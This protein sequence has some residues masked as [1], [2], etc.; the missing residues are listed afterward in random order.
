MNVA[1]IFEAGA[2]TA[3]SPELGLISGGDGFILP[4]TSDSGR[5]TA[6][7]LVAAWDPT[8]QGVKPSRVDCPRDKVVTCF[9]GCVTFYF[10]VYVRPHLRTH[11]TVFVLRS[12]RTIRI[13][14]PKLH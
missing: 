10:R 7:R 3:P 5:I 9:I 12:T 6:G 4:V 11:Q 14:L 13:F 8:E 2:G 1:F